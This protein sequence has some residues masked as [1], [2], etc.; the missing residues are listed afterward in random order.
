MKKIAIFILF[1]F[2]LVQVVPAMQSLFKQNNGLIFTV[3]EEKGGEKTDNNEKKEKKDYSSLSLV[4]KLVSA[5][6]C[7]AFHLA[8]KI[9]T[10]PCLENLT[11]PPNFC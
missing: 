5:K 2:A 3:D 7:A 10:S 4:V 1:V 8:E 6:T 11:P 9:H